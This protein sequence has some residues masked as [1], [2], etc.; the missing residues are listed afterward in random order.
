MFLNN[1]IRPNNP[2]IIEIKDGEFVV[3]DE[4]SILMNLNGDT[5]IDK[6]ELQK[7]IKRA[8]G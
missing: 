1:R 6:I 5:E 7:R 4:L 2:S 8:C 3:K